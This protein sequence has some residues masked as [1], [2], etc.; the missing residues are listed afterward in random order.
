MALQRSACREAGTVKHEE[1][2]SRI[3]ADRVAAIVTSPW[4]IAQSAHFRMYI[5]CCY[6]LPKVFPPPENGPGSGLFDILVCHY[7]GSDHPI[8][9][10]RLRAGYDETPRDSRDDSNLRSRPPRSILAYLR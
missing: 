1:G 2:V 6:E 3:E 7:N 8:R 5:M 4:F 9:L 10:R